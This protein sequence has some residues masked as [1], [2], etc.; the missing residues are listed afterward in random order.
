MP[1]SEF[2]LGVNP[3]VDLFAMKANALLLTNGSPV[4]NLEVVGGHFHDPGL[5]CIDTY[6]SF[7]LSGKDFGGSDPQITWFSGFS[8]CS[9][10]IV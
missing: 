9:S 7:F 4:F 1:L 10:P 8:D 3:Q 2:S 6:L 5:E